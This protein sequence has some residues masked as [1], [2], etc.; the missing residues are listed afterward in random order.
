[1]IEWLRS[2]DGRGWTGIGVY[3]LTVLI[4]FMLW[5]VPDLRKDE[6]FK[7]IATLIVG[8]AFVNG[9]VSFMYSATKTGGELA[10]KNAD[11]VGKKLAAS[12]PETEEP[13]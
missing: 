2:I 3:A 7:T 5:F 6:F 8:T 1:M 12:P 9:V 13:Q 11:I 10:N 4:F